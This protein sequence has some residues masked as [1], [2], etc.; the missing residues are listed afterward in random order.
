[1]SKKRIVA[2]TIDLIL[3]FL[4]LFFIF[5]NSMKNVEKSG[6]DSESVTSLVEQLPP[7]KQAIEDNKLQPGSL[8]GPIRSFAHFFEFSIL[9]VELMLLIILLNSSCNIKYFLFVVLLCFILGLSDE[10]I[11]SFS[12]RST[13]TVDVLK[14]IGG[15]AFGAFFVYI[16]YLPIKKKLT[17]GA[18]HSRSPLP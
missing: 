13:E 11:Q 5:G 3:I 1:M 6:A 4:T 14:D 18:A 7:I 9:G 8:E 16:I 17:R 12:D 15:G 2:I 10:I